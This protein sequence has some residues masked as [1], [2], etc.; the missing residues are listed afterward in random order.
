MRDLKTLE[1]F[2]WVAV[3]GGFRAAAAKLNTTQPAVSAR[4]AQ[5]EEELGVE[6]FDSGR[7]R[8]VL[9]TRG[10]VLLSYVERLFQVKAEMLQAVADPAALRGSFRLGVSET[11]VHTWLSD[12]IEQVAL[13]FPQIVLDISVDAT[14]ELKRHLRALDIDLALMA[15]P[16]EHPD[17]RSR[18]LCAYPYRF[19]ASAELAEATRGMDDRSLLSSHPIITYPK[20]T[21]SAGDLITTLQYR[22]GLTAPRLW[23]MS[24]IQTIVGMVRSGRGIGALSPVSVE[25]E[26]ASGALRILDTEV[27]LPDMEFHSAYLVGVDTYVKAAICDLAHESAARHAEAHGH[28]A[29]S[30]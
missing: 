29:E 4:I 12:L 13:V 30:D 21:V 24:S 19:I 25:A 27:R 26:L 6:L 22:L 2:Y 10:T 17:A 8:T 11:L 7:R 5:L 20:T 3:L 18:K 1:T 15:E 14:R 16:L 23:G 28:P 9:T